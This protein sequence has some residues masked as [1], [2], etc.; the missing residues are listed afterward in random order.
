MLG[1]KEVAGILGLHPEHV[2]RLAV[3]LNGRKI[4]GAWAFEEASVLDEAVN[5]GRHL[6]RV[7]DLVSWA[8]PKGTRIGL[9]VAAAA[10]GTGSLGSWSL[11]VAPDSGQ[12]T[13]V[14]LGEVTGVY[15]H[16]A[17]WSVELKRLAGEGR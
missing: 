17:G 15:R 14:T 6:P 16:E 5:R 7:G 13:V 2:R 11:T 10:S 4:D 9:I 8:G 1:L 12:Q 3:G